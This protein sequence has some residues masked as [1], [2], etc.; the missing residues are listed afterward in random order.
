MRTISAELTS[1]GYTV[2]VSNGRHTW[3]ADEPSDLGGTDEGPNPY[4]LLLG[5]LAAC[6]CITV[7]M[8]CQR[9]G[10]ELDAVSAD[11]THDRVHGNDCEDCDGT[12][13]GGYLDRVRSRIFIDGTFTDEQ[14]VRLQEIAQRCPVH[15]TLQNGVTFTTEEVYVG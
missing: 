11:Y 3:F 7:S 12:T 1:G 9:K 5:A 2:R 14:R 4:E 10:W 13:A 8:Y 15:K 6:T